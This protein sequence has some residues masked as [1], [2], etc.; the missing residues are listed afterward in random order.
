[1]KVNGKMINQMVMVFIIIQMERD[2]KV[3]GK[4][5]NNTVMELRHG[6]ILLGMRGCMV[7]GKKMEEEF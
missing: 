6:L 5:I 4:M 7:M 1:M 3:S 2:M